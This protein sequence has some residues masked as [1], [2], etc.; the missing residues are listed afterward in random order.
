LPG[1]SIGDYCVG[2][3]SVTPGVLYPHWSVPF[4]TGLHTVR[5]AANLSAPIVYLMS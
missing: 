2:V 1:E 5:V 3:G 4:H